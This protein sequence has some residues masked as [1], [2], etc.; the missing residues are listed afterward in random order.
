M[1]RNNSSRR[2]GFRQTAFPRKVRAQDLGHGYQLMWRNLADI[3]FLEQ[4]ADI[5]R[6]QRRYP[7]EACRFQV[8]ANA[9]DHAAITDHMLDAEPLWIFRTRAP[10]VEGCCRRIPPPDSR[11]RRT[12]GRSASCPRPGCRGQGAALPQLD[13]TSYRVPFPRCRWLFSIH[14]ASSQS[15]STSL[16]LTGPIRFRGWK[17]LSPGRV[18]LRAWIQVSERV[19]RLPQGRGRGWPVRIRDA[20]LEHGPSTI[21]GGIP[22]RFEMDELVSLPAMPRGREAG[23]LLRFGMMSRT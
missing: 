5:N 11:R 23:R 9:G 16:P 7:V 17:S 22:E 21:A 6:L 20:A 8:L 4:F 15:S 10:T 13:E 3:R 1:A 2:R 19:R 18:P 14:R 12:A